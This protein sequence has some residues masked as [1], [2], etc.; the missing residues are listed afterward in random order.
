M[1]MLR[2]EPDKRVG[3]REYMRSDGTRSYFFCTDT[4]RDL[5]T[6]SGFNEVLVL[7][8]YSFLSYIYIYMCVCGCAHVCIVITAMTY[9]YDHSLKKKHISHSQL[10]VWCK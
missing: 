4:V 3:F 7:Y 1:T 8:R 5:F 6:G 10:A 2:F 9:H